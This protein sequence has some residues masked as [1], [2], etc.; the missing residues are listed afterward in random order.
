VDSPATIDSLTVGAAPV[1]QDE[2]G[3]L[4]PL[5]FREHV[6]FEPVRLFWITDVPRGGARGDH[7]HKACW[8]FMICCAGR[9]TL[10]I[11][12]GECE[13]ALP[14]GI[15]DFVV[16]PPLLFATVSFQEPGATL[17]VLCNRPYEADDYLPTRDDLRQYRLSLSVQ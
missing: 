4:V 11:Y 2:R 12:D 13:R 14:M 10:K 3:A 1:F 6:P 8:Q 9:L 7:A 17:L 15:G 5:E 16:V